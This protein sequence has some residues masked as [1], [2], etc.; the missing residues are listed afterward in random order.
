VKGR[1]GR[2]YNLRVLRNY[3]KFGPFL[4]VLTLCGCGSTA[5]SSPGQLGNSAPQIVAI[6]PASVNAG[7]ASFLLTLTGTGFDS[8]SVVSVGST[9]LATSFGSTTSLTA[10]VPSSLIQTATTLSVVVTNSTSG[11]SVVS[12]AV[13]LS[14]LPAQ[15]NFPQ[16]ASINPS[17]VYVGSPAV[18]VTISGTGF[19]TTS[20]ISIGQTNFATTFVSPTTLQATVPTS[21][22]QSSTILFLTVTNTISG[23]NLVSVSGNFTVLTANGHGTI[24][25]VASV[26]SAG[27]LGD[28]SSSFPALSTDGRYVAF[29]SYSANFTSLNTGGNQQIYVRD[30]CRNVATG[31]TRQTIPVTVAP[32]GS[33]ANGNSSDSSFTAM[34]AS[35]RFVVFVSAATNL[36]MGGTNGFRHIFIRDTCIGVSGGCTP[37]TSL[38]S[39]ST[40][41]SLAN[42]DSRDPSVS[43]DG[44]FVAFAS[45]A[46][47]FGSGTYGQG[48]Q[49]FVRDTCFGA[50]G[51]CSPSTTLVSATPAGVA[52][53]LNSEAPAISG[54]GRY[55]AFESG[56]DNLVVPGTLSTNIFLRDTCAGVSG[57]CTPSTILVSQNPPTSYTPGVLTNS[58]ISSTGRHVAFSSASAGLL[59][60]DTCIGA[61]GA[62]TPSLVSLGNAT[63]SAGLSSLP[64]INGD[65][66][67]VLFLSRPPLNSGYTGVYAT[68]T[69]VGG[70]AGCTRSTLQLSLTSTGNPADFNSGPSALAPDGHSA[71][72][73]SGAEN[74]VPGGSNGKPQILTSSTTF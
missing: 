67:V 20:V 12:G 55:V 68:T 41:G 37:S 16:I 14:V 51:A 19:D 69:C 9:R 11:G 36:V 54:S 66:S 22:F 46:T 31:C 43:A 38:A 70:V 73:D 56:A 32:D 10:T 64:S 26:S 61:V 6:S 74:L 34:S 50:S 15:V 58:A 72:I 5:P 21:Y 3:W 40:S 39:I 62:C 2:A 42:G 63:T 71:A 13:N 28:G 7:S 49:V 23:G 1:T 53:D 24:D 65:G 17:S 47:N 59:L 8:S 25:G 44:R 48:D 27:V 52:G 4:I 33:L 29:A 57:N 18:V 45:V 60:R 30:T 35:G